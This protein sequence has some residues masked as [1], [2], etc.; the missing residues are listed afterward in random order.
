MRPTISSCIGGDIMTKDEQIATLKS[1]LRWYSDLLQNFAHDGGDRA[2]EA[3]AA[4]EAPPPAD[5]YSDMIAGA[6]KAYEL[7]PPELRAPHTRKQRR[8]FLRGMCPSHWDYEAWCRH[9]DKWCDE[10]GY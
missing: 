3:L 1:A 7:L 5:K 8:S 4:V 2:R 6:L 10:N 9:V